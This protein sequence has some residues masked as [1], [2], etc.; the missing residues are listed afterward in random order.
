[1]DPVAIFFDA[2]FLTL[3]LLTTGAATW[4]VA[5][6]CGL[7]L[8][9]RGI[10]TAWRWLRPRTRTYTAP[11]PRDITDLHLPDEHADPPTVGLHIPRQPEGD[12]Q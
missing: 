11:A 3:V 6:V 9:A 8:T 2:P 1:M 12:D 10:A 4:L 5:A 7:V